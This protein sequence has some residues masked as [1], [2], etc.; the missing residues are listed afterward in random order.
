MRATKQSRTAEGAAAMRA[1]HLIYDR[2]VV[3]NDPYAIELL[4]FPWRRV[5]KNPVLH[6]LVFKKIMAPLRPIQGQVLARSQFAEDR[7]QSAFNQGIAQCVV[8][9][10]GLDTLALRSSDWKRNASGQTLTVFEL[11]H[12]ATQQAKISKLKRLDAGVPNNVEF[13]AV[14]FERQSLA[15]A[16]AQSSFDS[17]K[18]AFF[19]WLGVTPYLTE[20]AIL[21][22]LKSIAEST[23]AGTELVFDY[24]VNSKYLTARD[25]K[26]V[27]TLMFYTARLSEPLIENDFDP[28]KFPADIEQ[29]GYQLVENM[30]PES[31]NSRYFNGRKDSL[32]STSAS[33]FAHF[34]RCG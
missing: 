28:E 20:A 33:Y 29:L 5:C 13:V 19:I 1:A 12:P 23:V 11:D 6:W 21:N 8:V 32:R 18:P 27:K 17:G 7:L 3:F 4:S 24:G 34:K 25:I 30:S 10:A 16:L 15:D 14:D 9:G 26:K 31:Q 2:P 22:T